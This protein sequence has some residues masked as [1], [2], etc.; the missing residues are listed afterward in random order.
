MDLRALNLLNK[1]DNIVIKSKSEKYYIIYL[2]KNNNN[3]Y[4][5][6]FYEIEIFIKASYIGNFDTYW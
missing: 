4:T 5:E 6:F 2:K 1:I 3:K